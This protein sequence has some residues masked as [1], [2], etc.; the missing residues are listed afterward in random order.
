MLQDAEGNSKGCGIVTFSSPHDALRAISLLS[1]SMLGDRQIMVGWA[2]VE[3]SAWG[4][5]LA[6]LV[7]HRLLLGRAGF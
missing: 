2:V 5:P 7:V 4:A 3:R 1:N 6:V